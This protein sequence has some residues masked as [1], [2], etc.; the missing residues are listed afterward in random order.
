M[1]AF[2]NGGD[3]GL[4][5]L[6][7]QKS[8]SVHS[9]L[10]KDSAELDK[11]IDI[12]CGMEKRKATTQQSQHDD[13]ARPNVNDAGLSSALEQHFGSTETTSTGTIRSTRVASIFLG[14]GSCRWWL[15]GVTVCG[16]NRVV[17]RVTNALASF[18]GLV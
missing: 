16:S 6:T 1:A 7:V 18:L 9:S 17:N 5:D 14:E 8:D 11:G 4:Q 12:V 13:T 10:S 3:V 2:C 15:I